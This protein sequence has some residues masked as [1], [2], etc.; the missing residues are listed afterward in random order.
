MHPENFNKQY[1]AE[2]KEEKLSLGFTI[3]AFII[4]CLGLLGLVI[5]ITIQRK[6][7]IGV[8][9]VLGATVMSI[10]LL[11]SKDFG[12]LVVI[13]TIIA[14]PVAWFLMNKWLQNFAYRI[15]LRWWMFLLS[16]CIAILIALITVSFQAIKAAVANP[17]E[18][19]RSE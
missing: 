16:G 8:R 11:V 13:S 5:F 4:A 10:T 2:R 17:V 9:K 18:S 14:V 1:S 15:E 6:K 7:E 19:L 12:K 3:L